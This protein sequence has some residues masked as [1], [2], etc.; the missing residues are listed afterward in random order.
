[1]TTG[2]RAAPAVG[3]VHRSA[4]SAT[5]ARALK[6]VL[7]ITA[8]F[9]VVEIAGGVLANSLALLADAGHMLTDVAAIGLSLFVARIAQRPATPEKTYGYL[10]LEILA[11]LINGTALFVIAGAIVVEAVRRMGQPPEV[12]PGIL[13]GVAA[14]GLVAN[15]VGMRILRE[16]HRHSLNVRGAYLHLISDLLGS[17][18]AILAGTIIFFTGWFVVDAIISVVIALLILTSAWRL[19]RESVDVLLE[20]T[21]AHISLSDVQ[22]RL[23]GIPGVHNVHDLH[24]WTVTSGVVAM[25]G[26]V[27]VED[28]ERNQPVLETAQRRLADLGIQHVTMQIEQNHTCVEPERV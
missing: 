5:H 11:A 20:G 26:H 28:P 4:L 10:R 24:V 1:M 12:Q 23:A 22:Q 6:A 19:V 17:V 13:F 2:T 3:C 8:L 9:M 21:P 25:S 18:G 7:A 27:V 16:G 14:A 15:L